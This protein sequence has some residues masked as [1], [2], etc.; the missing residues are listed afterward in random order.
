VSREVLGRVGA[1]SDPEHAA[2]RRRPT[3]DGN[4]TTVLPLAA[5]VAVA[6]WTGFRALHN[7]PVDLPGQ[8]LVIAPWLGPV[9]GILAGAA[10]A[11]LGLRS[12]RS[13]E[14][15]GLLF[16]GVFGALATVVPVVTVPAAAALVGGGA[17]A[18]VAGV[19][20]DHGRQWTLRRAVPALLLG[21]VALSLGAATGLLQPGVRS[22][23]SA[24]VVVGLAAS[25]ALVRP[26]PGGWALG[27]LA[28]GGVLW[29][30]STLPFV[31]GAVTLVAFGLVGT[32][33]LLFAAGVGGC[34]ATVT[35]TLRRRETTGRDE[36]LRGVGAALVLL[37]G[38]PATVA[39]AT[40]VVLG[41]AL[42][43][44]VG[45]GGDRR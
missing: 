4:A 16:V 44:G 20:T 38:A 12:V 39:G 34:V 37:A 9:A 32:P 3:V 35:G 42:L 6:A 36:R 43:A 30:G 19:G 23:G 1:G 17:V 13:T 41:A 40:A 33:L 24:V 11:A 26:G 7:A 14:R 2:D 8:A 29:A 5:L 21:G 27:A 22:T 45:T 15:V 25:P 10:A 28:A 18:L 31:T